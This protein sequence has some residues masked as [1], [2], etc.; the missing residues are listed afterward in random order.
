ML[1]LENIHKCFGKKEVLHG[2][3][4]EVDK[5]S[6]Y[7]LIG[8]NGAGKTTLM[9]IV[10][11]IMPPTEGKVY[12][13]SQQSL[14]NIA[15]M[16]DTT[17]LYT[18]MNVLDEIRYMGQLR[19]LTAKEAMRKAEPYIVRLG[20][21]N[22]LKTPVGVL[23]KGTARKVQFVCTFLIEP[24][25]A[26]LDEPFSGLDPISATTME[27]IIVEKKEQGIPILLSTHQMD[28][29]ERFCNHIFLIN[30]GTLLIDDELDKL[31]LKHLS[32]EYVVEALSNIPF[33]REN[34]VREEHS[35]GMWQWVVATGES[36]SY[37]QLTELTAGTQLLSLSR[38][39]PSLKDIFVNAVKQS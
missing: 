9:R 36:F 34:V 8:P 29:A 26:I 37:Q 13:G 5:P 28:Q 14:R 32:Q 1:K 22:Y 12:Y 31:K 33:P 16:P 6:I 20:L 10:C 38:R 7:G 3:T 21:Q 18:D 2:I 11:G 25:L 17:G 15:Y 4:L 19:G 30:Q 35:N 23:S 24:Y 27:Q 39:T